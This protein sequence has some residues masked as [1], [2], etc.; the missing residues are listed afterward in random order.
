MVFLS[1]LCCTAV[2]DIVCRIKQKFTL[3]FGRFQKS[4][5]LYCA[6]T[7][8]ATSKVLKTGQGLLSLMHDISYSRHEEY[9]L[10]F[11]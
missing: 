5:I 10:F 11:L 7:T 3:W 4:H 2:H 8:T 9:E 6:R 1:K